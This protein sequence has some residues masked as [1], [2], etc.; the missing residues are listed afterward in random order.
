MDEAPSTLRVIIVGAG[1]GGTALLELFTRSPDV[2]IVGMADINAE[3][4]GLQLARH[5]GVRTATDALTLIAESRADL[6]VDVTG[7]PAVRS[8]LLQH[9]PPHAQVMGGMS[10]RLL[11]KLAQHE[12]DLRDQLIQAEK[13]ASIGTLASG[14]A[15]E[16]N[17]PLYTITGLSEHLHDETRPEVVR[18]YL[19][20][21]IAAGQRIADIVQGLNAFARRPQAQDVCDID[22]NHTLDEAVKMA[23]RATVA[24]QVTVVTEYG[25]VPPI[26]GKGDE[27]L[28]VFVNLVTNA[29]QAMEG[30][31]TLTLSTVAANGFVQA[32]VRDTGPGIPR[33]NLTRIF[34]PFF[35]TKDQGK[36]TGLGLHI[37]RDIVTNYGGR[38]TAASTLGHGAAFTVQLPASTH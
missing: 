19:D 10:A 31:G 3:A 13:L 6:I 5:L 24:D 26:R 25:A 33:N 15:H 38:I 4:P 2:E 23:R 9:T 32:T 29:V 16:I 36:G 37:V 7:N 27:L 35:T 17:N 8:L 34:D 18:E 14:I 22:L 28:Q 1:K 11:W 12:R 20:E 21:I 30:K